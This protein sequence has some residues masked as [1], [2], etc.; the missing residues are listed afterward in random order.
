MGSWA[1]GGLLDFRL[2]QAP[3]TARSKHGLRRPSTS[4]PGCSLCCPSPARASPSAP[5]PTHQP[6]LCLLTPMS[7]L[8]MSPS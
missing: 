2:R 1:K 6:A 3:P 7:C 5:Q 4:V 8:L